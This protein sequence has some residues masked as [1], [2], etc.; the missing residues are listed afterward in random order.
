MNYLN[1][2]HAFDRLPVISTREVEKAFPD[3]DRNALTRWQEKGYLQKIR[4]GFYRFASRPLKSDS[5][6]FF[7]ANRIY[8]PSYVSLQSAMRW[9]DFI[10]E[11]VFTVTSVSTLKTIQFS[12]SVGV[13]SYRSLKPELFWGYHLEAYGDF[14]IKI[15]D[16]AKALL[17]LLYLNPHLATEDH[18][19][20]LRLNMMEIKEKL[21]FHVFEQYLEYFSSP[22]LMARAESFMKFI[23]AHAFTK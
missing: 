11:G 23:E 6:I 13:F 22:A 20:E 9:Y 5:D 12:T 18:F 4:S 10:P 16:P 19:F 7:I 21:D 14:R 17:D 15:A 8:Q 3:F 1:F 2:Q